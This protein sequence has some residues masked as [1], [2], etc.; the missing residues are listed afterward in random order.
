MYPFLKDASFCPCFCFVHT[1][2]QFSRILRF[3][4]IYFQ[5][6]RIR[7]HGWRKWRTTALTSKIGSEK[8]QKF[9]YGTCLTLSLKLMQW[10]VTSVNRG[11]LYEIL[12][13]PLPAKTEEDY[14]FR[15]RP[16]VRHI[17]ILSCPNFFFDVPWDI[18][19][20]FGMWLYLDELQI[21]YKFRSGRMIFGWVMALELVFFVK[22]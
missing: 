2:A 9:K 8:F 22:I 1:I 11:S 19:F 21:K 20:I 3:S 17:K 13:S 12:F 4:H 7:T 6:F 5:I 18:D 14:S 10:Y 16:S 15:F